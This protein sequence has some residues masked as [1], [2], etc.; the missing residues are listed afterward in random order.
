M[1]KK[2]QGQIGRTFADSQSWWPPLDTPPAGT[3]NVVIVLLDD[4]GYAQFGAYGSDIATPTFDRL[5]SQGRRYANFHTTALCSPTRACL[6]TG[7]NHHSNGMARVVELASGFPGYNATIPKENGFLSE[8]LRMEGYAT[9]AVGKW[10]LTPATEMATGSPRDKWPLGRGFDR[11]YGFMGGETDQFHPELVCDNHPVEPPSSPEDGYH[12][13]EDLTD[14]AIR[15]LADL[16]GAAPTTPFL[17]W[18]APGACH[19]PHQAPANYIERYRGHFDQGWDRWRDEVFVRQLESGLLPEGTQLSE[20]P[21]WVPPWDT[22]SDD[23]QRLAARLMEVYA[24]FLTHTDAQVA[25]LLDFID[26]LG[27]SDDTIVIVMSDN[28]ASA[29]GGKRGSFNEQYFF[30]FIPESLEENL[31]RIDDLGTPRA[32]NHYPWGW[33]WAG[34]TPLKRF[35]RDTHE[36]GVADPLIFHWPARLGT[37]GGTRH[38]YVHAIDVL[39]TLLDLIGIDPPGSIAGVEQSPIEGVSFAPTLNDQDTEGAHLIQYYEMLGSRAL[40]HDGWKAVVFHTPPFV[41][42]DG[43]D[44]T[45]PFEEDV[46]ELYHVAEDFSEVDDLSESHPEKLEELK[47]LWWEEAAKFQVLP[48]NNQPGQF[49]DPR[50]RRSRYEFIGQVGPLAE[51]LA[52]NLKNRS[53]VIA[54][55]LALTSETSPRGVIAAHGGHSG[56]YVVFLDDGRLHFTYNYVATQITTISAEVA[57]PS[58]P[59]HVRVVFTRT[60]A[61]GDVELFYGDVPV[62][63]GQVAATTPLTYGTPGF[64]IGFQPAGPIHPGFAGR[65]ELSPTLLRRVVVESS[66]RDPIRDAMVENRVDLATQ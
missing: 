7:R 26:E 23:E 59:V 29:E 61:G 24:G 1:T 43:S 57:L 6:L 27:E 12:L 40:Y 41:A 25:R 13:T 60:G 54:A 10:H 58:E 55:D 32:N 9:F 56:G 33:A 44:T 21:S 49:G 15:Y 48:L 19:A 62:G 31:K 50:Y 17:L 4:V 46:W 47:A 14:H 63:R 37:G 2:F 65:A 36:G 42:Y 51:A 66:G 45:K 3:P 34:N 20:R 18:F 8:I 39:P 22:L 53:F 28:G 16:R 52:P 30:N 38:Q 64:A 11:Y 5:A 35:K